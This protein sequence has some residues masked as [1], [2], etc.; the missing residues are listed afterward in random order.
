MDKT[1][2]TDLLEIALDAI[3]QVQTVK[4]NEEALQF[5]QVASA[6]AQIEIAQQLRFIADLLNR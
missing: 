3:E 5:I 2:Q 4:S 1:K 6:L